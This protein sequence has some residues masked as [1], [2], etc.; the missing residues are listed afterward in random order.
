MFKKFI[1]VLLAVMM[2]ASVMAVGVVTGSAVTTDG[3]T[4]DP[5]KLYF[6]VDGTGWEMG[7]R[8]KVAFHI[9]GGDIENALAW[10]ASKSIG[11]ATEGESGVFEIDPVGGK[12]GYTL[13]PGVQYKIIFVRTEGK[14]WTN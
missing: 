1:S 2:I 6:D 9:F 4:P 5:N 10:G 8:N 14:N 11:T 12:Q 7:E 3:F 13:N